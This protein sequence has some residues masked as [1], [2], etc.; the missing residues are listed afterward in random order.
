M[1]TGALVLVCAALAGCGSTTADRVRQAQT[2]H[3][4]PSPPPP[5]QTTAGGSPDAIDA[6][7]AFATTY[8]NW[9]AD[10][11][12]QQMRSLATESVGQARSAMQL[13]AGQTAGDYE[14]QRGGI[15]NSG[16]VEAIA[17]LYG[18]RAEYVVVTRELTSATNTDAYQG[19][20]PAWHLALATV[21]ELA[22]RRWVLSRWQPES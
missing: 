16:S 7:R 9:T 8:I 14:L 2:T 4:Y 3:E 15:A 6:I 20:R 5:H 12:S 22:G 19:L 18:H 21:V 10:T 13:A 1:R 17:P 11:V